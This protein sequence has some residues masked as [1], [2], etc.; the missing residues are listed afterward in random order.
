M[1]SSTLSLTS[2]LDGGGWSSPR[3]DGFTPG[4]KNR[5]PLYRRLGGLQGQSGRVRTVQ[6]VASR[7]TDY[8]IL[9]HPQLCTPKKLF[10]SE[11]YIPNPGA[12]ICQVH[13]LTTLQFPNIILRRWYIMGYYGS[14]RRKPRSSVTWSTTNPT[15]IKSHTDQIPGLR[16]ER[17]S[18]NHV[19][20]GTAFER[21]EMWVNMIEHGPMG[22]ESQN[23][24]GNCQYWMLLVR[25]TCVLLGLRLEFV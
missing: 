13:C 17:P 14:T 10:F 16:S 11:Q 4:K 20:H 23:R 5:Y 21:K 18:T 9:A 15:L 19:I 8:A 22:D 6:P 12:E 3:P 7:Y 2:A 1:Y 24:L 25:V